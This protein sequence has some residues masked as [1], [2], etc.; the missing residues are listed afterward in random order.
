MALFFD[1]W[2]FMEKIKVVQA[3]RRRKERLYESGTTLSPRAEE[4]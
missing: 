2:L 1:P 4:R 3:G